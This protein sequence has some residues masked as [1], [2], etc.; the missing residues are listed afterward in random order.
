MRKLLLAV[1]ALLLLQACSLFSNPFEDSGKQAR[2]E[3]LVALLGCG[4]C[5]TPGALLGKPNLQQALAGSDTGI[6]W[7]NPLLEPLPGILYPPNLT[8]DIETGIG[9][10]SVQEVARMIRTGLGKH[11]QTRWVMPWP[12]YGKLAEEDAIAI[13]FYL[14]SLPPVQHKVPADLKPGQKTE[15]QFIHLGVYQNT[16]ASAPLSK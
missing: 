4:S 16:P 14:K 12:S 2:G 10:W 1:A 8:P 5:H 9:S 15:S 7:N 13:A 11:G 6:A 3:Y